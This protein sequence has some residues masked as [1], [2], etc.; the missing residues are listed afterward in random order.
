[1]AGF[2]TLTR[3]ASEAELRELLEAFESVTTDVV[4]AHNGRIVKTIGDEV[5]FVADTARGRA[6]RSRSSCMRRRRATTRCR[7]CGS[8]SPPGRWSAG[9]ATCTGRR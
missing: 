8:G 3:K 6:P 2:T 7:R 9:S 1:M 4:G 5:L